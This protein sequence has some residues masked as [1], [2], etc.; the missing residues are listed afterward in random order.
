MGC[1]RRRPLQR[2]APLYSDATT[3]GLFV[4]VIGPIDVSGATQVSV[5]SEVVGVTSSNL[6]WKP[7]IRYGNV[8]DELPSASAT[9]LGT[10]ATGAGIAYVGFADLPGTPRRWAEL[11]YVVRNSA[12]SQV[13]K[14]TVF[15]RFDLRLA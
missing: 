13:E 2:A 10:E 4:P 8:P 3:T 12:G 11:G 14:G 15:A 5:R 6:A 7:A 9:D 1:E